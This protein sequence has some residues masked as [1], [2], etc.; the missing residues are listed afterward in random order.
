MT[1]S[2]SMRS[3]DSAELS[4][5]GSD[6]E[7]CDVAILENQVARIDIQEHDS[8][9]RSASLSGIAEGKKTG[10]TNESARFVKLCVGS[11]GVYGCYLAYGHVQEEIF[12][13]RGPNQERF[14]QVWFLQV[15]ECACNIIA[16]IIGRKVFG[17]RRPSK[18]SPFFYSGASQVFA[19]VLT[20][21]SLAAGLSYPVCLLAKSAK[22]VPV[23]L[24]QSLMGRSKFQPRDYLFAGLVVLGTCM[25][26]LGK[27]T[28]DAS[29]LSTPAGV[30]FIFLSLVLDGVTGAFQKG[31]TTQAS[32]K[33]PTTYDFLLFTNIAMV[34]VALSISVAFG[35]FARGWEFCVRNPLLQHMMIQ[36]CVLSAL[37]Q[38]CIYFIVANFDPVV[39]ATVTTTRK[40]VSVLWSLVVR[41]YAISSQ[42]CVGLTLA[43]FGILMSMHDKSGRETNKSKG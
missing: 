42:G 4:I 8:L 16:G 31:L 33:Q 39:C 37:G 24:G 11:L 28:N 17:G 20:N 15:A 13:Y 5:E 21:M 23:M 1:R 7:S 35:D 3:L 10:V 2:L 12:R 38:S 43:V 6:L 30:M 25:L 9:Q 34:I 27:P 41:S 36:L 29:S 19:K 22:V 26:S 14:Q 40:I 32:G 18:F